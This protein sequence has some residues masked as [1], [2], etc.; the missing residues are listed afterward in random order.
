MIYYA[1]QKK[2]HWADTQLSL[3]LSYSYERPKT[4]HIGGPGESGVVLHPKFPWGDLLSSP[5][6]RIH[7]SF[8]ITLWNHTAYGPLR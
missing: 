1:Y 2:N 6:G 3:L 8:W 7:A 5:T 4:C